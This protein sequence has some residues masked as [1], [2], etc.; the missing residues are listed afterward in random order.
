MINKIIFPTIDS[1]CFD[2]FQITPLS[3]PTK[4]G[5]DATN[6]T[7]M[8]HFV[9]GNEFDVTIP[10]LESHIT[11]VYYQ[12]EFLPPVEIAIV[13]ANYDIKTMGT[14]HGINFLKRTWLDVIGY[15]QKGAYFVNI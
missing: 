4:F 1:L 6:M 15:V 10:E 9:V 3:T 5:Q 14:Y 7:L 12:Y 2:G 13:F 8:K 11:C